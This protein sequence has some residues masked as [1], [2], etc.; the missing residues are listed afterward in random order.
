MTTQTKQVVAASVVAGVALAGAVV[1]LTTPAYKP[2]IDPYSRCVTNLPPGA[3]VYDPNLMP[4][5]EQL[6]ISRR[7]LIPGKTY[8]SSE[9]YRVR[10]QKPLKAVK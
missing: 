10:S 4:L 7:L 3:M 5:Y 9:V 8:Q 1:L 6:P 2:A